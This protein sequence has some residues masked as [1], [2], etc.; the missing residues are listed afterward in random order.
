MIHSADEYDAMGR[1]FEPMLM[2][3]PIYFLMTRIL[4]SPH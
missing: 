3:S 4:N 1:A 2:T